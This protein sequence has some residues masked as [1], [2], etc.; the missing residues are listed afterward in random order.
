MQYDKCPR[1]ELNYK[2]VEEEY[3]SL[4]RAFLEG[5][6]EDEEEETSL[7]PLCLKNTID[8]DELICKKCQKKRSNQ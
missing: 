6:E 1:C 8:Y 4:C 7:C 5:K 3:C 2:L